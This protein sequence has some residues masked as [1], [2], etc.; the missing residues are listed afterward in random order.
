M[1]IQQ[2]QKQNQQ[3]TT[4]YGVNGG[5]TREERTFRTVIDTSTIYSLFQQNLELL[6]SMLAR[7]NN[8]NLLIISISSTCFGR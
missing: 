6:D 5:W 7:N 2:Q 3:K 4:N 8:N 1:T